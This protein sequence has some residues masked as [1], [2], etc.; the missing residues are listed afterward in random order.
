MK[1][2]SAALIVAAGAAGVVAAG[3]GLSAWAAWAVGTASDT[4]VADGET[5]PRVPK[6]DAALTAGGAPRVEW[7][8]V[9]FS[10]GTTV[11]GYTVIRHTTAGVPIEVCKVAATTLTCT[12]SGVPAGSTVAYTVTSVIGQRWMGVT[13]PVS[14]SVVVPE[15]T[16]AGKTPVDDAAGKPASAGDRGTPGAPETSTPSSKPREEITGGG[17]GGPDEPDDG[18]GAIVVS[19]S[20]T[21]SPTVGPASASPSPGGAAGGEGTG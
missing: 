13:S 17:N 1:R 20:A 12:D 11:G 15:K 18:S 5:L 10:S 4:V 6:P 3:S 16:T 19:P 8:A 2:R 7:K 9:R 14:E 21:P